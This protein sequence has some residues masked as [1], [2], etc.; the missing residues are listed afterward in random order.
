MYI[1]NSMLFSSGFGGSA[2]TSLAGATAYIQ[3]CTCCSLGFRSPSFAGGNI[4][5]AES[6]A[7]TA[8]SGSPVFY[9][10]GPVI[11]NH[12]TAS[13]ANAPAVMVNG[14]QAVALDHCAL[15]AN[16]IAGIVIFTS[17]ARTAAPA[18]LS[19]SYGTLEVASQIPTM[20]VGNTIA[21]I[22]LR[23]VTWTP[24]SGALVQVDMATVSDDL[25][26]LV[27]TNTS[28]PG[29]A[30]VTALNSELQGWVVVGGNSYAMINIQSNTT[31]MGG[32]QL[33]NNSGAVD[34]MVDATSTWFPLQ[35][36]DIRAVT[37]AGNDLSRIGCSG[38]NVTYFIGDARNAWLG[39][40]PVK[41]QNCPTGYDTWLI[42]R[43]TQGS[44]A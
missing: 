23:H 9:A 35:P 8:A 4:V 10:T 6:T 34:V 11:A 24:T 15:Y 16:G 37:V 12:T 38:N 19:I 14:P 2:I 18:V 31:W 21:N 20:W 3:W 40:A 5:V 26:S 44:I 33:L 29:Q 41:L 17:G 7:H 36:C 25:T 39:P 13:A 43:N 32:A 1:S 22:T 42:P 30:F 27:V 28:S